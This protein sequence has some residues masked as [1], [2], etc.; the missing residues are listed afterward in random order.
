MPVL[1]PLRTPV[2]A[3][4]TFDVAFTGL[5]KQSATRLSITS[6]K[7]CLSC[8]GSDSTCRYFDLW[9]EQALSRMARPSVTYHD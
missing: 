4:G 3:G 1:A 5:H 2:P 7:V 6:A 9:R 8:A